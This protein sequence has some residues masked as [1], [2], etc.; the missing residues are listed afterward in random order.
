MAGSRH[1]DEHRYFLPNDREHESFERLDRLLDE[2]G[3]AGTGLSASSVLLAAH[4]SELL[5]G[6][7]GTAKAAPR[8]VF[9]L[10]LTSEIRWIELALGA[11]IDSIMGQLLA[12]SPEC[13]EC[14][15][16]WLLH[17][18]HARSVIAEWAWIRE[19]ESQIR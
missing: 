16:R 7:H 17:L 4:V 10:S 6:I 18:L 5:A 1:D 19:T 3:E 2:V 8:A 9:D 14:S 11:Q 12:E 15:R 13:P